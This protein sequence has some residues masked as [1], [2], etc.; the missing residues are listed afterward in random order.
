[1]SKARH[2]FPW[3]PRE[4]KGISVAI[5]DDRWKLDGY[6]TERDLTI[7]QVSR[8]HPV[9]GRLTMPDGS[10]PK[11]LLI[12]GSGICGTKLEHRL[13]GRVRPDGT[14]TLYVAVDYVYSLCLVDDK[15]TT[16]NWTGVIF[17]KRSP[18][19]QKLNLVAY[20]A[21]PLAVLVASGPK[22]EPVDGAWVMV[23]SGDGSSGPQREKYTDKS[24]SRR[25]S[26]WGK[27]PTKCL[28]RWEIGEHSEPST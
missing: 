9:D 12:M 14:F 7:V 3:I 18:A 26:A 23:R 4:A 28:S 11:G 21:V 10:S 1:M 22:Q 27:A 19:P 16:D 6:R 24:G 25:N 17:A 20:P 15:W 2:A 8:L 5:T 13:S